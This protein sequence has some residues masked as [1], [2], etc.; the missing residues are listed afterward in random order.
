[1]NFESITIIPQTVNVGNTFLIT[2]KVQESTYKRLNK[3]VHSFLEKFTHKQ[4]GQDLNE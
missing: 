3:Y 2:V 1:M 4:L